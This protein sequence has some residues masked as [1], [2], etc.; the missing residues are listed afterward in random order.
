MVEEG[1]AAIQAAPDL[2][3]VPA[4]MLA[5]AAIG[6]SH[7]LEL[8]KGWREYGCIWA[9]VIA[10]PGSRKTA[11]F[12]LAMGPVRKQAKKLRDQYEGELAMYELEVEAAKSKTPRPAKPTLKRVHVADATYEA[13]TDL[14]TQNPRGLALAKDELAG[15]FRSFGQYKGGAGGDKQGTTS[16]WSYW[17]DPVDRKSGE[18]GHHDECFLGVAGTVQP[19]A[20]ESLQY[21]STGQDGFLDRFLMAYPPPQKA[22]H[23]TEDVVSDRTLGDYEGVFQRLYGLPFKDQPESMVLDAEAKALFVE[24]HDYNA[25]EQ[26]QQPAHLVNVWNKLPAQC[27]RLIVIV[28]LT[29]WASDEAA[30]PKVVDADSVRMAIKL[31]E[32]FKSHI[33]KAHQV[34]DEDGGDRELRKVMEWIEVQKEPGIRPWQVAR[35]MRAIK[36]TAEA[37]QLLDTLVNQGRGEWRK[38]TPT[39]APSSTSGPAR[40]DPLLLERCRVSR[41]TEKCGVS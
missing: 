19:D 29:R 38:P 11:T 25:D 37:K 28:H 41:E 40:G 3:A 6:R 35:G 9:V 15:W 8:R 1:A 36:T 34:I 20:I 24:W 26:N 33:H 39:A 31:L 32:Y 23:W 22:P 21:G 2:I 16:F 30:K 10:N 4:L 14:L 12:K 18:P 17:M 27:G 5:G 7:C 13:L